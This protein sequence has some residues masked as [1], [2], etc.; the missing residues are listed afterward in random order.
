MSQPVTVCSDSILTS[1]TVIALL[2]GVT[3]CVDEALV[4]GGGAKR[5]GS[6][7]ILTSALCVVIEYLCTSSRSY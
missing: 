4:V 5:G 6:R 1:S 3:V 2:E 7:R